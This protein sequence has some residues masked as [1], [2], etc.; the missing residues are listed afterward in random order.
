MA[1][2]RLRER[3]RVVSDDNFGSP[4]GNISMTLSLAKMWRK[5]PS[6][7]IIDGTKRS[8][9]LLKFNEVSPAIGKRSRAIEERP[10]L[11]RFSSCVVGH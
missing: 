11:T 6:D 10:Q 3:L 1:D 7:V 5:V 4:A 8:I 2:K 9:F